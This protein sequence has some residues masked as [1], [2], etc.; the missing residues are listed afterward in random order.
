M[1]DAAT[2]HGLPSASW[3]RRLGALALDWVAS[4]LVVVGIVGVGRYLDDR[5]AGW[6][7][8]L[9]FLAQATLL[10][11]FAGGSFGQLIVGVRVLRVDGRPL[12]LLRALLRTALICLVI[13]PLVFEPSTGRGLHDLATRSGAYRWSGEARAAGGAPPR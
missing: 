12:D 4:I 1:P 10:T 11:T 8:L 6:W 5:A 13:P 2:A 3:G 7:V 9:A